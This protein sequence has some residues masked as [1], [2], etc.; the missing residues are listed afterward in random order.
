MIEKKIVIGEVDALL[1]CGKNYKY[2]DMNKRRIVKQIVESVVNKL[3]INE[4]QYHPDVTIDNAQEMLNQGYKPEEVF[5][6]VTPPFKGNK[7]LVKVRINDKWN[8]L[9]TVNNQLFPEWVDFIDWEIYDGCIMVENETKYNYINEINGGLL[10]N[11]WFDWGYHF[12]GGYGMVMLNRKFNYIDSDG[13]LKYN[14]WVDSKSDEFK[15]M[16]YYFSRR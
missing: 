6:R 12:R 11:Q 15:H 13:N 16:D 8:V 4:S 1:I 3:L 9:N 5:D 2:K 7:N 14:Q 10:S